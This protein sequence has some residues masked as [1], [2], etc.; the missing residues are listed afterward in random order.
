MYK[1]KVILKATEQLKNQ[2]KSECLSNPDKIALIYITDED[3]QENE[4]FRTIRK[5]FRNI[6]TLNYTCIVDENCEKNFGE[7]KETIKLV[8]FVLKVLRKGVQVIF[9]VD[10]TGKREYVDIS[11]AYAIAK[12]IFEDAPFFQI[13]DEIVEKI[14]KA[15]IQHLK[16][17]LLCPTFSYGTSH[18][19]DREHIFNKETGKSFCGKFIAATKFGLGEI[20]DYD[21]DKY[22]N[23]Y[24]YVNAPENDLY[25]CKTCK[26][27]Y[28]KKFVLVYEKLKRLE[29]DDIK[30]KLVDY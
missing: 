10:A 4:T 14:K 23:F 15:Y 28:N 25:F 30:R 2:I 17:Q 8:D 1:P 20:P 12:Y 29:G 18:G 19:C 22:D 13:N 27:S 21:I 16:W 26:K 9:V 3:K 5:V 7:L 6:F 11:I 24:E